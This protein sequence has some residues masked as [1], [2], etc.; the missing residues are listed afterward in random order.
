MGDV[1][2]VVGPPGTGKT[3]NLLNTVEASLGSG[4]KPTEVGFISFTK[5]AADE[6]K[7]RAIARFGLNDDDLPHFR[8]LHSFAF[9]DLGLR[10][11]QVLSWTHIKELGEKL[12]MEF[13]GKVPEDGDIYGMGTADRML[14]LDG[15]AR[16]R[17]QPLKDVW[18]QAQ[19][20]S[21]DWYELERFSRSLEAFKTKRGLLDYTDMVE[22]FL[23]S[24]R[25]CRSILPKFRDLVVDEAQDLSPLQWQMV[26]KLA[27][28]ADRVHFGGD[29]DQAIYEWSGADV[30]HFIGL[31]GEVVNL[32]QSYRVPRAPHILAESIASRIA[33]RRPKRW[34]PRDAVG[35]VNYS[36]D[37]ADVDL[38]S[39]T[40]LLL[41]RN[42]YMLPQLESWCLSQGFSFN[43]VN[44]DPLKSKALS[45]VKLWEH[46]RKNRTARV[47]EVLPML[48]YMAPQ[49]FES[50]LTAW[51]KS[52]QDEVEV[53]IGQLLAN[54]L[55]TSAIWHEAL[56]KISPTERDY[57]IAARRRGEPLLKAP[58][59]RISTIHSV[60]GG[61]ADNVLLLTDMS[62]RC[63]RNMGVKPDDEH[64]VFYVA[65]T[66][67][68]EGLHIVLPRSKYNYDV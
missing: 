51:L 48:R 11:E 9:R 14:F 1:R 45:A 20:D 50:K 33:L 3:T 6:G 38:S 24:S 15:L 58:R 5:K 64:R 56:T 55:G 7:Q 19:E 52:L 37:F 67:C 4:T 68:R 10:R 53:D 61:E 22:R 34:R 29:D 17:Q 13:K 54:G 63:Y 36:T 27:E 40:W 23:S 66:R 65:A 39:G 30:E 62:Q 47:E 18:Q 44:R 59:I 43:S 16:N 42:G 2:I 28:N 31:K 32:D 41:A 21:I 60:K 46:L 25:G 26:A 57:F 8:T 49:K 12:G 35:T